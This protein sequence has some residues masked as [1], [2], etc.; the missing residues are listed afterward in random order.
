[1]HGSRTRVPRYYATESGARGEVGQTGQLKGVGDE[2]GVRVILLPWKEL[3]R[4]DELQKV[5][6]PKA[7]D[8]DP[9]AAQ[10][11]LD[12]HRQRAALLSLGRDAV[13]LRQGAKVETPAE[14]RIVVEYVDDW[15]KA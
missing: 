6:H 15:R 7:V 13:R 9:V 8:G 12:I 2:F 3:A 14:I 11:V 5:W 10:L 4:L 1:M